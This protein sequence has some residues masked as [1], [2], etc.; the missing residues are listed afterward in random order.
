MAAS[1][2]AF[3][4]GE[5]GGIAELV[6][7]VPGEKLNILRAPV[8][9]ELA[10]ILS[11]LSHRSD[12]RCL[13][14]RSGKPGTFI[15]GADIKEIDAI[16]DSREAEEKSRAGQDVFN[17]LQDL[18]FPSVA[19]I[20]G[21]ALGGGLELALACTYR[22]VSD[23]PKTQLG[24]PETGLGIVPGFGGSYRLPRV[25]GLAQALR[26]IL[27]GKPVDGP[28]AARMGLA[29]ACYPAAF[30]HEKA[31]A[32]ALKVARGAP[33]LPVRRRR[34]G[35][36]MTF[37]MERNPLG[38]ALV[39]RVA[40]KD[41]LAKGGRHYPALLEVLTLL[42]KTVHASRTR[43][44]ALERR[45][46]GRTAATRVC[47]NLIGLYFAREAAR[48][49]PSPAGQPSG[50]MKPSAAAVIGAGVMGGKIAW[51]FA[52]H[53]IP[54]VMKDVSW[55]AVQKGFHSAYQ[56]FQDLARR[57]RLDSRRINLGMHRLSGAVEYASL[58]KPDV[59]I[60]AVVE[61]LSV[62]KKVLA[63]LE[64]EVPPDALL[65]SNT[66]S[67]SITEMA[68]ALARP[69]R[70]V[71]MHFF[72]PPSIM[73]LV[74]IIPGAATSAE[75]VARASRLALELGKTPIVV[76]DCPGFLVN[77]LLM[78]YLNECV[79]LV[80][81]GA[82]F[83][84]VDK[85]LEE[86]GMPMGPFA[87]LDEIGIDV[88]AHVARILAGAFAER[89]APGALLATV[90]ATSGLLG[91]KSGKGFYLYEKIARAG[92]RPRVNPEIWQLLPRPAAAAPLSRLDMM[93]RPLLAMLNEAARAL[94]EGV[95][96]SA[97][98]LDLALVLG[99]GFPP[100]R[101]GLLHWVEDELGLGTAREMLELYA[102]TVGKR[103]APAPLINRLVAQSRGFSQD[104]AA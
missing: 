32:F 36:V 98:D 85:A 43:G 93:H 81:E 70:F 15:A 53:D 60:E 89:M 14:I 65:A 68:G 23:N 92:A 34:R 63:E 20:D 103:F 57:G 48:H 87:L 12:L 40:R 27:S 72:N 54:A 42:R 33:A 101:G 45:A 78:P 18:S 64:K 99:T 62:K 35:A 4:L 21:P 47:R 91:K 61:N 83:R 102:R 104:A 3:S 50:S 7:D 97:R 56:T 29:H 76:K 1:A 84:T 31:R 66:S 82:D 94:E 30:L 41:V 49:V 24:L 38:R 52:H 77:R 25:V 59:V 96:V 51:L 71:G 80:E 9:E 28:R 95:V 13:I 17:A 67:L 16:H 10:E 26:M 19:V 90:S 88:A 11:A 44:L 37:L 74:E 39:F 22:L 46:L 2:G 8:M 69:E 55:D 100:F 86:F 58:G 75:A 73:P 6:L 79:S 5:S